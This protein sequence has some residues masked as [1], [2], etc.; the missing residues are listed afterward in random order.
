M[1][2]YSYPVLMASDIL[3]YQ[4]THVPVGEDQVQH[5]ELS[6]DIAERF[7]RLFGDMFPQPKN[8]IF[9]DNLY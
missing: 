1:S 2:L 3:L 8:L 5:L 6:R 9:E 4:T 7:N